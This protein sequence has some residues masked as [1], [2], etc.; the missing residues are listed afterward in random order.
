MPDDAPFDASLVPPG[1]LSVDLEAIAAEFGTPIFVYDEDEIRRRAREYVDAVRCRLRHVRVEGLPLHRDGTSRR[2]GRAPPRLR[3]RWRA[4]GRAPRRRPCRSHRAARQQQVERGARGGDR[5]RRR[6]HRRRLGRRARP[7][8][9]ADRAIAPSRSTCSSACTPGV[10][11]HTHEYIETGT[12]A[13][14]FGFTMTDGIALAALGRVAS[15]AGLRLAGLHCHI[16]SQ[17]YRLDAYAR[18]IERL[19]ALA[20][21]ARSVHGCTIDELNLGGGLGAR[22][23]A[24]DPEL[25]VAEYAA[26]LKGAVER[27]WQFAGLGP[28]PRVVGRA[29]PIDRRTVRDH[30]LPH[31]H[32]EGDPR[33]RHVRGGRRWDERQPAS[34]ALRRGVRGVP[35]RSDR[36]A[37]AAA[38]A[39]SSGSTAS[40]AM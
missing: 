33:S 31:R 18:A 26:T 24:D 8:R 34:G 29:G 19:A 13:S 30:A 28:P 15:R 23:L 3:D 32:G 39:Q 9:C 5:G 27:S 1:L 35:P 21:E 2:R 10:E 38:A 37:A 16:G 6:P 36:R 22:Y 17:I 14:K 20:A 12:E 4:L 40:R 11:A 7:P 25:S